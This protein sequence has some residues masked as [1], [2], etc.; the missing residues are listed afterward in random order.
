M[1]KVSALICLPVAV[2]MLLSCHFHPCRAMAQSVSCLEAV[3]NDWEVKKTTVP[4]RCLVEPE[5]AVLV[6]QVPEEA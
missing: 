2:C 6:R 1:G 4:G 3:D 5:L